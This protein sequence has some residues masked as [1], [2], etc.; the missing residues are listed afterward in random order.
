MPSSCSAGCAATATSSSPANPTRSGR[1]PSCIPRADRCRW[2]GGSTHT[3]GTSPTTSRSCRASTTTGLNY[4]SRMPPTIHVLDLRFRGAPHGIAAF[5]VLG[6]DGTVLVET[7]PGST[8]ATLHAELARVGLQSSDI[9]D[10]LV[11]HIHLDHAGAAGWWAQHGARVHVH[12]I[13]APHLIDPERL[14]ASAGRIYGEAMGE[15]WGQ[16]LPA[17]AHKVFAH[18]DGDVILAGGLR[19]VAHDTPGHARHHF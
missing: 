9:R 16:F 10:V 12:H 3:P 14:L 17:P 15:L 8:L 13:G 1:T 7:G 6:P 2:T 5:V 19:F 18:H 4:N 11:T